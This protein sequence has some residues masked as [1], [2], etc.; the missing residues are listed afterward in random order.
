MTKADLIKAIST[1]TGIN[2]QDVTAVIESFMNTANTSLTE[3]RNIYLRGFGSFMLKKRAR[4]VARNIKQNTALILP[5]RYVVTFT[6]SKQLE[7]QVKEN[8]TEPFD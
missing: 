7:K 5:E 4:K 1:E 6:P 3:H 8:K 2:Q